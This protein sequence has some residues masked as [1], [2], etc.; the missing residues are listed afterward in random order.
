MKRRFAS[1]ILAVATLTAALTGATAAS[2]AEKCTI[3]AEPSSFGANDGPIWVS[4]DQWTGTPT[5]AFFY[6]SVTQCDAKVA[7]SKS[8]VK[9]DGKWQSGAQMT[10]AYTPNSGTTDRGTTFWQAGKAIPKTLQTEVTLYD[11]NKKVLVTETSRVY[12]AAELNKIFNTRT[13]YSSMKFSDNYLRT[14][15]GAQVS[16]YAWGY[17]GQ[18]NYKITSSDPSV[19]D[20]KASENQYQFIG[21]AAKK[22]RAVLT[23]TIGDDTRTLTVDV[24]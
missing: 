4:T 2:A 21:T 1:G 19:L 9:I 22:G 12:K 17:L 13:S 11:A 15:A 16:A 7:Y 14:F 6:W 10:K 3:A 20:L 18:G 8:R 23:I 5:W 24:R